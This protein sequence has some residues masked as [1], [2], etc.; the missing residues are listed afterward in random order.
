MALDALKIHSDDSKFTEDHVIFLL[1]KYRAYALQQ[2][3]S[4]T[5]EGVN[6]RNY[7]S[8]NIEL[9]T[10]IKAFLQD[11]SG[12]MI[13]KSNKEIPSIINI[14]LPEVQIETTVVEG[15]E[16]TVTYEGNES[17]VFTTEDRI[18]YTGFNRFLKKV[19]YCCI[20]KN[21]IFILKCA[22]N[23]RIGK[24]NKVYLSAIFSDPISVFNFNASDLD[25]LDEEFPLEESLTPAVL[26]LVLKDLTNGI[27]KPS[28]S[29]NNAQD[30]LSDLAGFLRRN[31]KSQFQK[32]ID[33]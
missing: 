31:M 12:G 15:E 29:T 14:S 28:D 1:N 24:I 3:Y 19:I 4:K 33:E 27:Y 26:E 8:I 11:I 9:K 20:D 16:N 22:D 21:N 32:Q 13:L 25:I 6:N 18:R 30:A 10:D 17:I 5:L 23:T 2:K 7:Q